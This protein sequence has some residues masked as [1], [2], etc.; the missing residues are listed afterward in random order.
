MVNK[1]KRLCMLLVW[2][3]VCDFST[4]YWKHTFQESDQ[5]PPVM[6]ERVSYFL[7]E[8]GLSLTVC[9]LLHSDT[10]KYQSSIIP[11]NIFCS[12]F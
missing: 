9:G 10:I 3:R 2:V 12:P 7:I 4:I 6:G 8:T 5:P 1:A 11:H